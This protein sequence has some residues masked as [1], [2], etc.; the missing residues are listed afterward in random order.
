MIFI[1]DNALSPGVAKGINEAGYKAVHVRDIGMGA[2]SDIDIINYAQRNDGI[3]I[4]ADTDFG[5]LLALRKKARPSFILFKTSDKRP[6][7]LLKKLLATMDK[8]IKDLEQGEVIVIEDER[9]RLR[10]LPIM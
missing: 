4:S 1:V 2:A 6:H 5:A 10:Q 3:I 9:I 7:I 8:V